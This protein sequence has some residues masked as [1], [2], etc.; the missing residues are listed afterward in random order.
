M[1]KVFNIKSGITILLVLLVCACTEEL[2]NEQLIE[3]LN[4]SMVNKEWDKTIELATEYIKRNP[5]DKTAYYVR[6]MANS[7]IAGH[8]YEQMISDLSRVLSI[9]SS[10]SKARFLRFQTYLILQEHNKA[11]KDIDTL[12]RSLGRLPFLIVWKGVLMY[13]DKQFAQAEKLFN[14]RLST[15]GNYEE[16]RNVYYLWMLSKYFD[17]NKEGALWDCA[18]LDSRGFEEDTV[19]MRMLVNDQ[20]KWENWSEIKIP[21]ISKKALDSALYPAIDTSSLVN[22]KTIE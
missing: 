2:T 8:N 22:E 18:F 14:E 7:N 6:A 9:D 20:L 1:F 5:G 3:Q 16:M 15:S 17:G 10:D 12:I 19:F 21:Y 13:R 11:L 4:Q